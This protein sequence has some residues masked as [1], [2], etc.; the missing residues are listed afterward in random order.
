MARGGELPAYFVEY[1]AP[2]AA[3]TIFGAGDDAQPIVDFAHTL[4]WRVTVADGR[5]H[6]ATRARFPLADTVRVI[7]WERVRGA[8]GAS[9]RGG[10][11]TGRPWSCEEQC[12]GYHGAKRG[13][14]G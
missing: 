14:W 5:A 12:G 3:L 6:L 8:D 9:L 13:R 10:L 7:D 4:G 2:A 1:L 11:R